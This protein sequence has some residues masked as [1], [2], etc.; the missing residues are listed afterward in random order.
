MRGES[1][2]LD[3][4]SPTGSAGHCACTP[5]AAAPDAPQGEPAGLAIWVRGQDN[6]RRRLYARP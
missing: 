3:D 2:V 1:V 5:E 4:D 6:G